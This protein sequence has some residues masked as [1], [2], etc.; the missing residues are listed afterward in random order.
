MIE[1]TRPIWRRPAA[2]PSSEPSVVVGGLDLRTEVAQPL[3]ASTA[4]S[5]CSNRAAGS[6][7]TWS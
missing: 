4:S 6:V 5:N 1:R 3:A 7:R 2:A